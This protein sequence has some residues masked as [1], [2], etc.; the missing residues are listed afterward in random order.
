MKKI[1]IFS[2]A[3]SLASSAFAFTST[4]KNFLPSEASFQRSET[5]VSTTGASKKIKNIQI[6]IAATNRNI[7]YDSELDS[8]IERNTGY[9]F[10]GRFNFN[11]TSNL[12]TSTGL[13]VIQNKDNLNIIEKGNNS[14]LGK[15]TIVST[16]EIEY[17]TFGIE[18][19]L[20][21][22]FY[23]GGK[24]LRFFTGISH[25]KGEVRL[26]NQ[27]YVQF[28]NTHK[29]AIGNTEQLD[30]IIQTVSIG[31]QYSLSNSV[32]IELLA[33]VDSELEDEDD[34]KL[35][36]KQLSLGLNLDI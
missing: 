34:E 23:P 2:M 13:R 12:S 22:D 31:A 20:N 11:I 14:T 3:V 17:D 35:D 29:V 26:K 36:V 28:K 16:G 4:P 5:E 9:K 30:I 21:Y 25:D 18:Q 24:R 32:N 27:G 10:E 8:S 6:G 19:R 7:Q 33:S 1:A 15:Y